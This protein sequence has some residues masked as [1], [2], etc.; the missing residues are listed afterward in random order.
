MLGT[1]I[2][3]GIIQ[4]IIFGVFCNWLAKQKGYDGLIWF[5][6]GFLFS[7][8]ALIAIAGAPTKVD[9]DSVFTSYNSTE[10][11]E[12]SDNKMWQCP[13]CGNKNEPNLFTCKN[14]NYSL[15]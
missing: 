8:L 7:F 6:L 14:C 3:I 13:K 4:G 1:F 2:F 10:R 11:N 12:N 15:V 5:L 9:K